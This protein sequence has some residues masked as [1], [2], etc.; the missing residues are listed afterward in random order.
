MAY[1]TKAECEKEFVEQ[2]QS[3]GGVKGYGCMAEG[4]KEY[5]YFDLANGTRRYWTNLSEENQ[6]ILGVYE[7]LNK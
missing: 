5:W 6:K 4:R 7:E 3:V 1:K 2:V